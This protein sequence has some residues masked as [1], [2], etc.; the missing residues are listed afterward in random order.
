MYEIKA[1]SA[2]QLK[3]LLDGG[4]LSGKYVDKIDFPS[5]IGK[6]LR[7]NTPAPDGTAVTNADAQ[8]TA[9]EDVTVFDLVPDNA[10]TLRFATFKQQLEALHTGLSVLCLEGRVAF[11]ET[12]PTTGVQVSDSSYTTGEAYTSVELLKEL[13]FPPTCSRQR[14]HDA[15]STEV[16]RVHSMYRTIDGVF[17]ATIIEEQP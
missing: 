15:N 8:A 7:F 6:A 16:P 17:V 1:G 5:L 4:I 10:G 13:G 14:I 12:V 11:K 3:L 2:A 9:M